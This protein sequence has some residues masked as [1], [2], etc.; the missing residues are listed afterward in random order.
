MKT[1]VAFTKTGAGKVVDTRIKVQSMADGAALP[2]RMLMSIDGPKETQL[3]PVFLSADEAVTV[4]TCLLIRAWALL[5]TGIHEP[6]SMTFEDFL[7]ER[8]KRVKDRP[9]VQKLS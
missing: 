5:H 9:E 2:I 7:A 4:A 8:M 3:L 6:D 1:Q